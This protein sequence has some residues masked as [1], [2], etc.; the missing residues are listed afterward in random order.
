MLL[1][2]HR[3][4]SVRLRQPKTIC[5][6]ADV[7]SLWVTIDGDMTDYEIAQGESRSFDTQENLTVSTL[8]SYAVASTIG[9]V[10]HAPASK[11]P[12][13]RRSKYLHRHE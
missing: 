13:W 11:F 6:R 3:Q 12:N 4:Q 9:S 7:G 1:L 5:I 8:D 10:V 2:L